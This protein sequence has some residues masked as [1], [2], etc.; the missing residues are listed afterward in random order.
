[1]TIKNSEIVQTSKDESE[2]HDF[3]R[4][5]SIDVQPHLNSRW[6]MHSFKVILPRNLSE[7]S[8]TDLQLMLVSLKNARD[9]STVHSVRIERELEKR[10]CCSSILGKPFS[11]S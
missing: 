9:A 11:T 7:T 5:V 2:V 1:M 6:R 3:T 8:D 10:G 4:D